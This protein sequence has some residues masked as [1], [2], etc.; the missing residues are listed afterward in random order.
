MFVPF[1]SP[2]TGFYHPSRVMTIFKVGD[3]VMGT[4]IK[5]GQR[6]YAGTIQAVYPSSH[7]FD[8][9]VE[10]DDGDE[11]DMT[12]DTV[13]PLSIDKCSD[14]VSESKN[15]GDDVVSSTS[16]RRQTWIKIGDYEFDIS[17]LP[18][19]KIKT[20]FVSRPEVNIPPPITRSTS[21]LKGAKKR[22]V[23]ETVE[24]GTETGDTT[25]DE[26]YTPSNRQTTHLLSKLPVVSVM[27]NRRVIETE[28]DKKLALQDNVKHYKTKINDCI[29]EFGK[30]LEEDG[31]D[32]PKKSQ[33]VILASALRHYDSLRQQ[34]SHHV[35]FLDDS[36]R[37]VAFQNELETMKNKLHNEEQSVQALKKEIEM[38]KRQSVADNVLI[39]ELKESVKNAEETKKDD[40]CTES[41]DHLDYFLNMF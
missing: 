3:R 40:G 19:R 10:F 31:V 5:W 13:H 18:K 15:Q 26:D 21:Q 1:L 9:S 7:Q 6:Y 17:S 39:A 30:R 22:K 23:D 12:E 14:T 35:G 25:S 2:V 34:L 8:Y 4:D 32:L 41:D 29:Q 36:T 20:I 37:S 11:F 16:R 38:M 27:R 28:A 33:P 24:N